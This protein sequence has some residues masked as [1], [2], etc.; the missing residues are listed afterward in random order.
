MASAAD[1]AWARVKAMQPIV[2]K[3][4]AEADALR[5]L[6]D[7][8]A[9]AFLDADVYR[10]QV[11]QVLGGAELDPIT[12][13]DLIEEVSSYDG[14]T[15][16][17]F[18]IGLNGVTLCGELAWPW[19]SAHFGNADCGLAVCGSPGRAVPANGGYNISGKWTWASG[20]YNAKMVGGFAIIMEG[21]KPRRLPS[22]A[23]DV[24]MFLVPH[25]KINILDTWHTGGM[26]GTG[27]TDWEAKDVFVPDSDS[28]P[29]F[30]ERSDHQAPIF[31]LPVTYFGLGLSAVAI[32][33]ARGA[34]NELKAL[35]AQSPEAFRSQSYVQYAVGKAEALHQSS[36]H[37]IRDSFRPIWDNVVNHR[38]HTPEQKA[39]ARGAYVHGVESSVTA[40]EL[41]SE[42]AGGAAVHETR[43]FARAIRDVHAIRGH[44]ILSR[45]FMELSGQAFMGM[46]VTNP[47]F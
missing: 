22:G 21:D 31:R 8:I 37:Y 45:R 44:V 40:V 24:R 36:F 7:P 46:P 20:I 4:R 26:R 30:T 34:I 39:R 14:S 28:A 32:G 11:P 25:N 13:F 3:H 2:L 12:A 1:A 42:A 27:S 43:G 38:P 10:L 29:V 23:P 15:G 9:Q 33:V 47:Q 41:C 6:P 5:R 19:L 17:N 35:A 18:T 16:W